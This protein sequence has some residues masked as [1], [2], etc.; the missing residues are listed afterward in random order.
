MFNTIAHSLV[1]RRY[2]SPDIEGTR[3]EFPDRPIHAIALGADLAHRR[4]SCHH[5]YLIF[6]RN[7]LGWASFSRAM[8]FNCSWRHFDDLGAC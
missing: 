4:S 3:P 1:P 5:W 7:S 2:D 8:C 6:D